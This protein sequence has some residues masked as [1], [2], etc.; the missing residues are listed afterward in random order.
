MSCIVLSKR[1]MFDTEIREAIKR[2]DWHFISKNILY[3]FNREEF[4][5]TYKDK[6]DWRIIIHRYPSS[7]KFNNRP[8]RAQGN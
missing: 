5:E 6:L 8:V 4:I 1:F 2:E 7:G 3:V